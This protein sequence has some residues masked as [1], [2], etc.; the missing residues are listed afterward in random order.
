MLVYI[1]QSIAEFTHTA[2]LRVAVL[3]NVFVLRVSFNVFIFHC[4]GGVAFI[5]ETAC[6]RSTKWIQADHKGLHLTG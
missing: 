2:I 6:Y 3:L 4:L 1:E 5:C